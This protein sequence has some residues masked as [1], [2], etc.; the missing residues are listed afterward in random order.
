MIL[1]LAILGLII[2]YFIDQ[3]QKYVTVYEGKESTLREA[4]DYY[5]ILKAKRIS[6]KY[7]MPYNMHNVYCF[8]YYESPVRLLVRKQDERK[9]REVLINFRAEKRRMESNI[10]QSNG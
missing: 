8:G 5:W 2:L 7:H 4:M 6:V 3:K 1:S 9:A 10:T